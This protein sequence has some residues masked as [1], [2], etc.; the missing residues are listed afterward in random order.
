MP[1][2]A[3]LALPISGSR[4]SRRA[5]C[6]VLLVSAPMTVGAWWGGVPPGHVWEEKKS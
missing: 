3:G 2:K 5:E 4:C 1:L 6:D